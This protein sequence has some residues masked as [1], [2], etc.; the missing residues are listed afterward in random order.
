MTCSIAR[1]IFPLN[2]LLQRLPTT[3]PLSLNQPNP[4]VLNGPHPFQPPP[5]PEHPG[6]HLLHLPPHH[7]NYAS[8]TSAEENGR[9]A[10][11]SQC[12]LRLPLQCP[13][14]PH[15]HILVPTLPPFRLSH[16]YLP[17]SANNQLVPPSLRGEE[18]TDSLRHLFCLVFLILFLF[19]FSLYQIESQI[20]TCCSHY[21]ILSL[22]IPSL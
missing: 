3:R 7:P 1:I 10:P 8:F 17:G 5:Q 14:G 11:T 6:H 20:I 18:E 21:Y 16:P 15:L 4:S 22:R 13:I 2:K 9:K 12:P 19:L